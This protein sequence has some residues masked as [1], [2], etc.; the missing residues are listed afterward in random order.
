ML[1]IS[2]YFA[3]PAKQKYTC[4]KNLSFPA[5]YERKVLTAMVFLC[6]T[7]GFAVY[8][9]MDND[10]T[11]KKTKQLKDKHLKSPCPIPPFS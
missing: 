6:C 4:F 10:C 5:K 11:D 8:S 3:I 2:L 1:V 7:F 9:M